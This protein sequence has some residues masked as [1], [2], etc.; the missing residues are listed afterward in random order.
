MALERVRFLHTSDWHLE[1]P[2]GGI[3]EVSAELRD[4]LIE[5]PYQAAQR[6][7]EA[8][9]RETVDFVLL[10]GDILPTE[11]ASPY[12][13]E[14]VLQQFEKL[15]EQGIQVYWVG[16]EEDDPDLWP[17]QLSLPENVHTFPVGMVETYRFERDGEPVAEIVGQSSRRQVK[18]RAA[19]FSGGNDQ[20]TRIAVGYGNIDQKL[21]DS[22]GIDYWA[23]G[24][25]PIHERVGRKSANAYYSGSPQGR[26]PTEVGRFS[27]NLVELKYGDLE[28]RRVDVAAVH[29]HH[30]RLHLAESIELGRL[31]AEV[32]ERLH[33]NPLSDETLAL[34][35]WD[36]VRDEPW[37]THLRSAELQGL[38]R[39]WRT[40]KDGARQRTVGI[41]LLSG[42]IPEPYWDE[43]SILGDFL[44]VVRDLQQH[45]EAHRQ[46]EAYLPESS[47][48][49]TVLAEL[50][51]ASPESHQQMWHEVAALGAGLL[52]GDVTL[53]PATS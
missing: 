26:S 8:A 22:Q 36:L 23:F 21:L 39:A 52:R 29:W 14:F 44:R 6:V 31:E 40:D 19:D 25:K 7:V 42:E 17:A 4:D 18:L 49:E 41:Q 38:M 50:K 9:I 10:A 45:P 30:E 24:G 33:Q 16:G 11:S 47:L 28:V 2:L 1:E 27:C 46:L 32:S 5:A 13:L 43:D 15:H 53:D 3:A 48:K 20:I 51:G 12:T 34:W 37:T 35:T